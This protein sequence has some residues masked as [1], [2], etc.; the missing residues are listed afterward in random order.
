LNV[1]CACK[2]SSQIDKR[3]VPVTFTAFALLSR[4]VESHWNHEGSYTAINL[5]SVRKAPVHA[6]V[7]SRSRSSWRVNVYQQVDVRN[8]NEDRFRRGVRYTIARAVQSPP[9]D[10]AGPPPC[11]P[12]IDSAVYFSFELVFTFFDP[13]DLPMS[14]EVLF[15]CS[16]SLV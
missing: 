3:Q 14:R 15:T 2:S 10:F 16:T 11:E 9:F 6:S 7:V 4:V 1:D 5:P 8:H 12:S 13:R